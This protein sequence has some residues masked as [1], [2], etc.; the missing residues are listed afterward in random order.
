MSNVVVIGGGPSGLVAAIYASYNRNKVTVL[1]RNSSPLKKLLLTGNG[2]CNYFNSNQEIS[3][4]NSSDIEILK[5]IITDNNLNNI[6]EFFDKIGIV[7]KIKNGYY[8]PYS[9][10]AFSVKEAILKEAEQN[11]IEIINDFLVEEVV[12]KDNKFIIN[13]N[14]EN[15]KFDNLVL[16]TGSKACP[17]TGSDGIGYKIAKSFNHNILKPLPALVQLKGDENYFK[18]WAGIRCDVKVSLYENEKFVDE[19]IGEIQLTN[20]G[21]S[22]ICVFNLSSKIKRGLEENKKEVIK[23]NFLSFIDSDVDSWIIDRNNKLINRTIIELLEGVINYKLLRVIL[24]KCNIKYDVSWNKLKENEKQIL[25]KNLVSFDLNIIDTNDFDN[26]QVCSGGVLLSEINP[27][28]MESLKEN[29]LYIV[30]E[31]LDVDGLCGGYNLTFSFISGMIAGS[32]IKG[33]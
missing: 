6:L 30:G 7:P 22:G 13:P 9:S 25:I 8:Y 3:N 5:S 24:K 28:T 14:K 21:V 4:Y 16:A 23:I 32:S 19:Q 33:D 26:A 12:K 10:L 11:N 27:E 1:E 20:Y 29:N 17:K 2:K 15:L 18:D 31:L